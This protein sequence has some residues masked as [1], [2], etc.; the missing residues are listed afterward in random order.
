MYTCRDCQSKWRYKELKDGK[1][2]KCGS[3]YL[4]SPP[5]VKRK[6]PLTISGIIGS[7]IFIAVLIYF[8]HGCVESEANSVA[9]ACRGVLKI[10]EL[11]VK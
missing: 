8:V 4:I 6:R 2:P 11:F 3:I 7:I 10:V 1:C 9:K 5:I